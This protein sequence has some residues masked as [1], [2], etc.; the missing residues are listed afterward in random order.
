M[1]GPL[2]KYL[3]VADCRRRKIMSGVRGFALGLRGMEVG[4]DCALGSIH[5]NCPARVAIG[6][7]CLVEGDLDIKINLPFQA[8]HAI[9]VG[10]N[11]FLGRSCE[12]NILSGIE[13]GDDCLIASQVIF[14]DVGHAFNAGELIRL[15]ACPTSPIAVGKDVW[16]GTRCIVLGGVNIGDGAVVGAGSIVNKSIPPNEVWAGVPAKFIKKRG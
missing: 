5:C 6:D 1:I 14:A 11:V 10:N 15:Q 9:K 4:R 12:F 2:A 7:S 13:I 16:I 3:F 8:G